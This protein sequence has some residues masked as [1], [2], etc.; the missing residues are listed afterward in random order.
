VAYT[1][2]Y[3]S[4]N[5]EYSVPLTPSSI[6]VAGS[7]A[8]QFTACAI[9]LLARDG[10]LSLD[11]SVRVYVPDAPVYCDPVTIRHLLLHTSGLRDHWALLRLADYPDDGVYTEDDIL[12]LLH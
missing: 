7:V 1:H 11:D 4:A 3:G 12:D 9:L 5:L 6:F 8:K 2:G 10:L